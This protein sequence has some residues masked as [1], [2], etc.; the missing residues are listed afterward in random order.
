M[1]GADL[2]RC[3]LLVERAAMFG[4]AGV[5]VMEGVESI[6]VDAESD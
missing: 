1:W 5:W 4:Y 2:V 6:N 3:D